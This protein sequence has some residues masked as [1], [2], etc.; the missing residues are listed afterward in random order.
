M[1]SSLHGRKGLDM[2]ARRVI[3]LTLSLTIGVLVACKSAPRQRPVQGGPVDTG[4]KTLTAARQY[5]EGRW[6][7]ESFE[8]FPP[9][10]QPIK[11]AGT[12]VLTYDN[13]GNLKMDIRTDEKTGDLLRKAGIDIRDGTIS[14]EGRTAVDMQNQTLTYVIEGQPPAGAAAGPLAASR[15]RH[16]QVEGNML[17]LTTKDEKGNALSVGRWRRSQ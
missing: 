2:I 17:T 7:L 5:L 15:P 16:W 13:F 14:S 3:V 4:P 11:L 8:V 1:V 9:G 6:T 12:G 10:Q